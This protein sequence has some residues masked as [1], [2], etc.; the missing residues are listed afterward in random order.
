MKTFNEFTEAYV[1]QAV[2][3]SDK[4]TIKVTGPDGKPYFKQ[5]PA[6]RNL[7]Q[8]DTQLDEIQVNWSHSTQ[9][10]HTIKH[11]DGSHY[12]VFDH[13]TYGTKGHEIRKIKDS[14]GNV[15]KAKDS[16]KQSDRYKSGM[17]SPSEAAKAWTKKNGGTIINHKLKEEAEYDEY[18]EMTRSELKIAINSAKKILDMMDDDVE[19]ERWQISEIV[20]ASDSLATVYQNLLA[21]NMDEEDEYD[22]EE[23]YA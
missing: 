10:Y 5:V 15:V 6:K 19:I 1:G 13:G 7:T 22:S 17:G 3:S 21:D 2:N 23:D 18:T 16:R 4:K 11:P 8:E 20:T 12:G 14:D 9:K